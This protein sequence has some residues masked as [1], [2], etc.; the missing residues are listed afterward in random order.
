MVDQETLIIFEK[1]YNDSYNDVSKYIVCNCSNIEDVK[2]IIQD[3]YL[4]VIKNITRVNS[5]NYIIGIAKNKLKDYY[6]YNYKMKIVSLFS[7][8]E[9]IKLIDNLKA[10]IDLE[11]SF[12]IKYDAD[13]VWNYL[14]KK[15]PIISKVFYL[16]YYLELSIVEIA[17]EL[18]IS[19]SSVK[20]YLYRTLK[21][22]KSN[23]ER[24]GDYNV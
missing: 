19:E 5:K 6:R 14:K 15:K 20:N 21:E 17:K 12:L 11:K 10:D 9:D 3:T 18:N 22:L 16:Y 4:E 1:L 13:M 24:N 7:S 23:S 8:K 2:D